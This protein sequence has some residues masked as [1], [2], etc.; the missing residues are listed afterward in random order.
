VCAGGQWYRGWCQCDRAGHPGLGP[1][2]VTTDSN[3]ERVRVIAARAGTFYGRKMTAGYVYT[4]AGTRQ[5]GFS[6]DGG[7][8]T[9]ATLDYPSGASADHAGNLLISD[10][11]NRRVRVVAARQAASMAST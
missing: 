9:K 4:I 7:P 2:V 6:G 3:N 5:S 11:L 1:V 10:G 8:A